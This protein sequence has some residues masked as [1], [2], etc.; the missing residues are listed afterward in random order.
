LLERVASAAEEIPMKTMYG[1]SAQAEEQ[2]DQVD[3]AAGVDDTELSDDDLERVVGGL[4]R[5]W[6]EAEVETSPLQRVVGLL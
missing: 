4:A 3:Q 2:R 1:R 5:P 6:T